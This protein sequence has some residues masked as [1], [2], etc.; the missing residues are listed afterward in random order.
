M[1]QASTLCGVNYSHLPDDQGWKEKCLHIDNVLQNEGV[2]FKN[3]ERYVPWLIACEPFSISSSLKSELEILGKAIFAFLDSVQNLYRN[4]HPVVKEILDYQIPEDIRGMDMDQFIKTFRLDI[5]LE[6][7][8][9]KVTEIEETYATIAKLNA[10]GKAYDLGHNTVYDSLHTSGFEKILLD[11]TLQDFVPEFQTVSKSMSTL[12]GSDVEVDF[13]S[14]I[15]RHES[16]KTWRFCYTSDFVQYDYHTRND[17]RNS[18]LEFTNPRFH[19]YSSKAV[20]TLLFHE[21]VQDDLKE[22]MGSHLYGTL[23]QS[24]PRTFLLKEEL[25]K[26]EWDYLISNRNNLVLKVCDT[27]KEI[28][29]KWGARGV[30]FG[31]MRRNKWENAL[32]QAVMGQVP[33]DP[34][35]DDARFIISEFVD[36]DRFDI[37]F[38][39]PVEQQISLMDRARIRLEPIYFRHDGEVKMH[40]SFAT[41]VNTSKKV[42]LGSHAVCAPTV[43]EE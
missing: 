1:T 19:A 24:A 39:N 8:K 10:L 2:L 12:F 41:F 14:N 17:I 34:A 33:N 27:Q 37:P 6:D 7:G 18:N 11:D 5:I 35:V 36:S 38:Y 3:I 31:N 13:F 20:F 21:Q 40:S 26:E 22:M 23:T 42:H 9:P 16:G 15:K 25:S 4:N 28:H 43:F 30:F 29:Y 32:K